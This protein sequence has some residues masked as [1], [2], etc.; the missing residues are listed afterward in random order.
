MRNIPILYLSLFFLL[1]LL[2]VGGGGYW[3]YRQSPSHIRYDAAL[4]AYDKQD[5]PTV[6]SLIAGKERTLLHYEEGC[7]LMVSTYARM[8]KTA[9]LESTAWLCIEAHQSVDIAFDGYAN[10]LAKQDKIPL[11]IEKLTAQLSK[12]ATYRQL[13]TLANLELL[14]KNLP[15]ARGLFLQVVAKADVW[16]MYVGRILK[17]PTLPEDSTFLQHLI[18]IISQ[19]KSVVPE[20]ENPLLA[21]ASAY[22]LDVAVKKLQAR[23]P[24]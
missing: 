19:K 21:K 11:A 13:A 2:S 20:V 14:R 16:S 23:M 9:E 24:H 1:L 6:I 3:V 8:E 7:E 22:K 18:E 5:L 4:A 15:A 10:S 17:S 12:D